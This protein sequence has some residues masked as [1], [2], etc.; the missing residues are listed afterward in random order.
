M[1]VSRKADRKYS[2]G[3]AYIKWEQKGRDRKFEEYELPEV[4]GKSK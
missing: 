3:K 2:M 1:Q 4:K